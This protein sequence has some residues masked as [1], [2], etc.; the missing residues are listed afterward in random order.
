MHDQIASHLGNYDSLSAHQ[1]DFCIR[2]KMYAT[3]KR[4]LAID[5]GKYAG[6]IFLDLTKA[7]DNVYHKNSTFKI[8]L[9]TSFEFQGTSFDLCNNLLDS[10]KTKE[11]ER[12]IELG[13][14]LFYFLCCLLYMLINE[15]PTVIKILFLDLHAN[16]V[17]LH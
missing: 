3:D 7:F 15:F 9:A 11:F 14:D 1:S 17:E 16:N 4:L 12:A 5:E 2:H 6:A 13:N 8:E 10:Y